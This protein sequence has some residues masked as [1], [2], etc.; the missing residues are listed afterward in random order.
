MKI[1][2]A[3]HHFP[4]HR[5]AGAELEAFRT[6]K[7]LIERGHE[8]EVI[9][10][11]SIDAERKGAITWSDD[12]Y[13]GVPV[14]RLS[15]NLASAP[16]PNRWEY[17]NLW[18]G[19]HLA[20]YL[21]QR[22]PDLFHLFSGYLMTGR[23]L[24]VAKQLAIPTVVTLMDFWFLCRRIT[25]LR[26]DGS[27]SILPLDPARCVRCLAEE[28]WLPRLLGKLAPTVMD[29]YWQ[30]RDAKIHEVDQRINFCLAALNSADLIINRSHFLGSVYAQAGAAQEKMVFCRQGYEGL[31]TQGNNATREGNGKPT[32]RVIYLGQINQ[33]KGV[34]TL[35]EAV[36]LLS[37]ANIELSI[38]GDLNRF[39]NYVAK[40]KRIVAEDTRIHL[41]GLAQPDE[42]ST[43]LQESD[44][45]V[46]PSI[47]YENSPNTIAE[48]FAHGVP[49]I[50]SNLGGMAELVHYE[51]NG[52]LFTAGDAN[53]LA[54]QL[55]RLLD[56]PYLL[57]QLQMGIQPVKSVAE[58]IDELEKLYRD[59]LHEPSYQREQITI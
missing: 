49:V 14:H 28:K 58:E 26:S 50:A 59:L 13:N 27:L 31:Q 18:I 37:Q 17:D 57:E 22:S 52:L 5:T 35:L 10:V 36:R 40:L 41:R 4:P 24:L 23:T 9:C 54:S 51:Q 2:I 15:F 25:M 11:E 33:H 19:E 1:I 8:V 56:E 32:L 6:A 43:L 53:D 38:Y 30:M 3:I 44:I 29:A 45:L 21:R 46:V 16:D 12:L 34:H 48:A 7:T 20:E 55:Q 42:I 47:W 39:P